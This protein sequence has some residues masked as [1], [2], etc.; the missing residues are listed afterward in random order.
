MDSALVDTYQLPTTVTPIHYDLK[1]CTDLKE[2]SF[3]GA[4]EVM[5]QFNADTSTIVM[6]V[7]ELE[8]GTTS[9]TADNSRLIPIDQT[10]NP[11]TQ[12][13]TLLFAQPFLHGSKAVLRMTFRGKIA[14]VGAGYFKSE[15]VHDEV[16]DYYTATFFE[17]R[18]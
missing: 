5:I 2:L 4:V 13:V 18:R 9:I 7:F 6:N 14:S 15:W 12:R 10:I 8:L 1:I 11:N 16:T 17:V 3:D